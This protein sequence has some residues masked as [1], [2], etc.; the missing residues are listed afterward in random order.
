MSWSSQVCTR[1]AE[2]GRTPG[3]RRGRGVQPVR[4]EG[5]HLRGAGR[6]RPGAHPLHLRAAH[7]TREQGG[8]LPPAARG[9]RRRGV[10]A[11]GRRLVRTPLAGR[12]STPTRSFSPGRSRRQIPSR[13]RSPSATRWE[14]ERSSAP[15]TPSV[16]GGNPSGKGPVRSDS[17][18][19][20]T[21]GIRFPVEGGG[22]SLVYEPRIFIVGSAVPGAGRNPGRPGGLSP[23]G[24]THLRVPALGT[25]EALRQCACRLRSVRL[26]AAG[27][28]GP[29]GS[30]GN[31][32]AR[33]NDTLHALAGAA[34]P[35]PGNI[36]NVRLLK[37]ED[38]TAGGGFV[39][40]LSPTLSWLVG[41]GYSAAVEQPRRRSWPCR[42]QQGP[43][44]ATALQWQTS[45]VDAWTALLDGS[46][47]RFST[48]AQATLVDLTGTW[49]PTP[50]AARSER[51]SPAARPRFT[52]AVSRTRPEGS[53]P[54][55]RRSFRSP[56]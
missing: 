37:V 24:T 6:S 16:T 29:G 4:L 54:R 10:A 36:P 25:V 43:L 32:L 45:P 56:A 39:Y 11:D 42:C 34:I 1:P 12:C 22:L 21:A 35:G 40:A 5:P 28:G 55:W 41:A 49:I 23:Q 8:H 31:R 2:R 18:V 9:R 53:I 50:G 26:L 52:T 17:E 46:N 3:A 27:H 48:G 30:A 13:C 38:L 33:W 7:A 15:V 51:I 14:S 47:S 20:P 44:G 19:D